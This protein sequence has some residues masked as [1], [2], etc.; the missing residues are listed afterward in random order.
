MWRFLHPCIAELVLELSKCKLEDLANQFLT[1]ISSECCAHKHLV[2]SI[3]QEVFIERRS[4]PSGDMDGM[5]EAFS[6]L[7]QELG[8]NPNTG[9]AILQRAI[10]IFSD[11]DP[12]LDRLRIQLARYY[13]FK[14][15]D[16]DEAMR[17]ICSVLQSHPSD[18]FVFHI[19]GMIHRARLYTAI[20]RMGGDDSLTT[21]QL[22][23]DA[24]QCFAESRKLL[25]SNEYAYV[26]QA[27]MIRC[28]ITNYLSKVSPQQCLLSLPQNPHHDFFQACIFHAACLLFLIDPK[29][30]G[31]LQLRDFFRSLFATW[32]REKHGDRNDAIGD[33]PRLPVWSNFGTIFSANYPEQVP[34]QLISNLIDKYSSRGSDPSCSTEPSP[35]QEEIDV[36]F[37]L[38][39]KAARFQTSPLSIAIG[40]QRV[41]QWHS[42]APESPWCSFFRL[43]LFSLAILV[44]KQS[45]F[46]SS[47]CA[48][49]IELSRDH[50]M[51]RAR[52]I[53]VRVTNKPGL[54]CL[55]IEDEDRVADPHMFLTFHGEIESVEWPNRGVILCNGIPITFNPIER[56]HRPGLQVTFNLGFSFFGPQ[57]SD[58]HVKTNKKI[59][60]NNETKTNNKS[61]TN[62]ETKTKTNIQTQKETKKKNTPQSYSDAAKRAK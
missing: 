61:N 60:S 4:T 58:V 33:D 21:I 5:K 50:Q 53:R 35:P 44:D 34:I 36:L 27:Q 11:P 31:T 19:Q 3:V 48:G 37:L 9:V 6:P 46:N 15:Q 1:L 54:G 52:K 20:S 41:D 43:V 2:Q 40:Q 32:T 24:S 13:S 39:F 8:K 38:F 16:H 45:T 26:A 57:A 55:H 14:L 30:P 47:D 12:I 7:I 23:Q 49:L 29:V 17:I 22:V 59:N 56:D 10:A 18:S 51:R 42:L 62:N 28:L 25:R